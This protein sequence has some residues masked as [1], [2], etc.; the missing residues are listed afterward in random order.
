MKKVDVKDVNGGAF[1]W[2]DAHTK[3]KMQHSVPNTVKFGELSLPKPS[4]DPPLIQSVVYTRIG[5]KTPPRQDLVEVE[6]KVTADDIRKVGASTVP[7]C[8]L[9]DLEDLI[10]NHNMYHK[11][12][13]TIGLYNGFMHK[14]L[15]PTNSNT[16]FF[17]A[18][19]KERSL[20]DLFKRAYIKGDHKIQGGLLGYSD[21]C[22]D[23][24]TELSKIGY[25]DTSVPYLMKGQDNAYL[26]P[27]L[28]YGGW[29]VIPFLPC[30][31]YCK[32]ALRIAKKYLNYTDCWW[33][34]EDYQ[35]TVQRGLITVETGPIKLMSGTVKFSDKLIFRGTYA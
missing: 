22:I 27:V 24:F 7:A 13:A 30:S 21:C 35:V 15:Q 17:I 29:R 9:Q 3:E 1:V 12:I 14:H 4:G 11:I 31:P 6:V 2:E 34:G 18:Y 20:L 28:R 32:A 10:D 25:I 23:S 8:N 16:G 26:T 19:S 33:K 5:E